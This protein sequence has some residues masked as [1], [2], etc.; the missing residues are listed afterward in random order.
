MKRRVERWER[1]MTVELVLIRLVGAAAV[2]M[3]VAALVTM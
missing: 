1:E 2:L 3:I